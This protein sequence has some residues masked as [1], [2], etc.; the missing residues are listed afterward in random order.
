MSD[1]FPVGVRR[2][3]ASLGQGPQRWEDL[4]EVFTHSSW[5]GTKPEGECKTIFGEVCQEL[6]INLEKPNLVIKSKGQI[7]SQK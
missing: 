1:L 2:R 6:S 3:Q 5:K 7:Q 4:S